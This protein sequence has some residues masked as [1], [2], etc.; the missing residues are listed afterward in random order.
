MGILWSWAR[1]PGEEE[2]QGGSTQKRERVSDASLSTGSCCMVPKIWV[3]L[4][5]F[6]F[7][8]KSWCI[9]V[10]LYNLCCVTDYAN[11]SNLVRYC[12]WNY[13]NMMHLRNSQC[14]SMYFKYCFT[15]F[16]M[17][18]A[19]RI[20]SGL[21]STGNKPNINRNCFRANYTDSHGSWLLKYNFFGGSLI[22]S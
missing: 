13:M 15:R 7:H 10:F 20:L 9:R 16:E 3:E 2:E 12:T 14:E 18:L 22:F 1:K 4:T 6:W 17:P 8:K 19:L 21:L 5:Y 11:Y